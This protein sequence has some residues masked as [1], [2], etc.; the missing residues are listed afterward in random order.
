[1]N[2]SG[3]VPR[4]GVAKGS[5]TAPLTKGQKAAHPQIETTS[6]TVRG[7]KGAEI[8]LPAGAKIPPTKVNVIRPKDLLKKQ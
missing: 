4:C 5:Q 1:M 7:N 3:N 2:E 8:G 6:G